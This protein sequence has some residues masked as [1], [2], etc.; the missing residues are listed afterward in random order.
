[1]FSLNLTA[2][3]PDADTPRHDYWETTDQVVASLQALRTPRGGRQ[4]RLLAAAPWDMVIVDEA[5][6]L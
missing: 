6:H 4:D 3:T 2:D 5:P 1:M